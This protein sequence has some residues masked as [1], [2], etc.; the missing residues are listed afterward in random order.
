MRCARGHSFDIAR[1]GYVNLDV[2]GDRAGTS[3]TPSMVA[4]RQRFLDRGHFAAIAAELGSLAGRFGPGA[5]RPVIALDLAGGTG[6]YLSAVLERLPSWIGVCLDVSK[7]ALRR[8]A[9]AHPR[10]AAVGCDVWRALPAATGAASIVISAFGPRNSAET[11]R[12][13]APGGAFLLVTPTVGHLREVIEDLGM[14][15]VDPDKPRRVAVSTADLDLAAERTLTYRVPLS[16]LDLGD[17]VAMGP[18]ARHV[19][20]AQFADRVARLP[21]PLSVTV[22]VRLAAY[23]AS[24]APADR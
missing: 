24:P 17:L 10:A 12:V 7:P 16:H 4:A 8:A 18:S 6:Y 11:V 9:R 1:Q 22:S 3:D 2:G 14:L 20:P 23:L 13:L 19:N 15:G 5:A 21:D